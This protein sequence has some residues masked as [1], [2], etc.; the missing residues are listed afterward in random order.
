[1]ELSKLLYPKE[2]AASI[3]G[4]SRHTISRDVILGRIA[5]K[6]YGRRVLIPR[7]EILRIASE[8]MQT[9]HASQ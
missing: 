2:E 5:A 8:G 4:I 1:M 7:D 6:R 9:T 3:L